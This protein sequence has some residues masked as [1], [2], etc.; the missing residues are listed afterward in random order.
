M[1][2]NGTAAR[3][4]GSN[5]NASIRLSNRR[6]H[7]SAFVETAEKPPIDETPF[8]DSSCTSTP[9][10]PSTPVSGESGDTDIFESEFLRVLAKVHASL[11]R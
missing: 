7:I 6:N 3:N 8:I 5:L 9:R 1:T 4:G 10:M 11:E 2:P